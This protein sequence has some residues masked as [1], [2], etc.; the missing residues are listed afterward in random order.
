MQIFR[1][2][3]KNSSLEPRPSVLNFVSQLWRQNL[4]R[5]I[6]AQGYRNTFGVLLVTKIKVKIITTYFEDVSLPFLLVHVY[7]SIIDNSSMQINICKT[8]QFFGVFSAAKIKVKACLVF[9]Y[10]CGF[11]CTNVS[12]KRKQG[13]SSRSL[14]V[15]RGVFVMPDAADVI[16]FRANWQKKWVWQED[17]PYI[18][19]V[20]SSLQ[21]RRALRLRSSESSLLASSVTEK[22]LERGKVYVCVSV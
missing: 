11:C 7:S 20:Y 21:G 8:A 9:R 6:W 18:Q 12:L 22:W 13:E 10:V 2:S 16:S 15:I 14:L 17:P 3:S 1:G 4:E 5:K 19:E